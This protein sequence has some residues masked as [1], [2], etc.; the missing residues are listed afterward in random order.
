LKVRLT[1]S[2]FTQRRF[3]SERRFFEPN[4]AG[5][6]SGREIR[7]WDRGPDISLRINGQF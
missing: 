2:D 4:R 1:L 7:N 3:Q 5:R 6:D